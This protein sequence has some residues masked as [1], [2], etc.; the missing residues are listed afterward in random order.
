LAY[1]GAALAQLRAPD[2]GAD[3][4]SID[5][6]GLTC[7]GQFLGS[8]DV[9]SHTIAQQMLLVTADF[10]ERNPEHWCKVSEA[11]TKRG[12]SVKATSEDA[13]RFCAYGALKNVCHEN[14]VE[15]SVITRFLG[16]SCWVEITRVNDCDGREAV[17]ALLRKLA[18]A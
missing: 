17:V 8:G 2:C 15:F 5:I 13:W 10:L 4:F 6:N 3:N 16:A 12:V 11:K 18:R 7:A 14:D 1:N 9:M